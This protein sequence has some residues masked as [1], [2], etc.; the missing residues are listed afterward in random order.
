MPRRNRT[1]GTKS[2]T[3]TSSFGSG[4]GALKTLPRPIK[5]G[6]RRNSVP[7]KRRKPAEME[8]TEHEGGDPSQLDEE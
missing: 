1:G 8:H 5:I 4:L 6:P 7:L 2:T 3:D